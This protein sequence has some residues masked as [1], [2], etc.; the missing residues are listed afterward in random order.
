MIESYSRLYLITLLNGECRLVNGTWHDH[1]YY[2]TIKWA[3]DFLN[4]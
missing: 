4:V 3:E 2:P 1:Y